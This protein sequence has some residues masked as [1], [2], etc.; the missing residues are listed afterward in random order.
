MPTYDL[1]R[2]TWDNAWPVIYDMAQE[3]C[4]EIEHHKPD[5]DH[6]ALR[7]E[8]VHGRLLTLVMFAGEEAVG[9][10]LVGLS[11]DVWDRKV[12]IASQRALYV[13]PDHRNGIGLWLLRE[14]DRLL[15]D[16]GVKHV[17]RRANVHR[18]YEAAS[19]VYLRCGYDPQEVAYV[20]HLT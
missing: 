16:L 10:N 17:T 8:C 1:R 13:R 19:A 4:S 5:V 3:H 6:E 15:K 14:T 12:P 9:Y 2:M 20:R 18:G 11:T 7:N